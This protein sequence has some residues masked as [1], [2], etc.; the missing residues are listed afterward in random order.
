MTTRLHRRLTLVGSIT[1]AVLVALDGTV[2]TVAQPTLQRDLHASFVQVQWTSTGYLSAVASLLV[3]AGRLGDRYGHQRL[4]I[5]GIL[6]FALTSAGIGLAPGIGWVIGLRVAQGIF[7]AL[8]QPATLGMLRATYP[9]DQLGMPIALR[10]SAI[11]LSAAAG[12]VL[13]GALVAHL[14]WRAVFFLTVLPGLVTGVLALAV[15]VPKE[16]PASPRDPS[17]CAG[18]TDRSLATRLDLP[19][20]CLLAV[21]LLFLVHTLVALPETGWTAVTVTGA[22][23]A[24]AACAAFLRQERRSAS[25]LLPL[26]FLSSPP[27]AAALA[28]L[29]S[30]SAALFGALFVSTYFLQ[31]VLGLDPLQSALRVLPLAVLMVLGAPAAAVLQ[32][33]Y[34]ARRTTVTAMVLLALGVLVLSQLDRAS[35]A[36]AI[37][38]GFLLLGAGFGAVMVTATAVLVHQ[39]PV[40]HAGVAG[41]LQQTAMNTGPTLGVAVATMLMTLIAPTAAA[42]GPSIGGTHRTPEA[43]TA[44]MST[45]LLV[46]ASLAALGT[47]AAGAL[48]RRAKGAGAPQRPTAGAGRAG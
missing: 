3:F 38:G 4:F 21:A 12:P 32:R 11:G 31:G 18:A 9:R 22:V 15:R 24:A 33:R 30:A 46:L 6:G 37:S 7:G 13:G 34:G 8:L 23:A 36:P 16:T 17:A 25:P 40:E 45:T 14:G 26:G 39:A 1:G 29:L 2:L 47:L 20:A 35:T 27:V 44:A 10:T 19:G 5:I 48:P 41:G 42:E 28:V 43:F